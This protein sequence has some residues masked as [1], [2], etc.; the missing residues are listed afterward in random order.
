MPE[1][2]WIAGTCLPPDDPPPDV[3]TAIHHERRKA[4]DG[5]NSCPTVFEF[6][7]EVVVQGYDLDDET[8][9]KLNIPDGENAVRM[10]KST[11][12][13]GADVLSGRQR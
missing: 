7:D 5:L 6:G 8:R 1:L 13:G 12:L 3:W 2:R 9:R 11:Y 4:S 10:P